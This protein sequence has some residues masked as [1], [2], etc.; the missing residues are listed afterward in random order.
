VLPEIAPGSAWESFLH[1]GAALRVKLA[2]LN[3][4]QVVVTNLRYFLHQDAAAPVDAPV[5]GAGA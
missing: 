3:R 5:H 2:L 1:G 4:R